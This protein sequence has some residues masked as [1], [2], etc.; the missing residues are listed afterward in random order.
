MMSWEGFGRNQGAFKVTPQ[1][2]HEWL[3]KATQ[4]F[5]KGNCSLGEEWNPGPSKY[6]VRVLTINC[7]IYERG[8]NHQCYENFVL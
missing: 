1:C 4:S 3:R 7:N 5:G 2:L 6:K 8:S